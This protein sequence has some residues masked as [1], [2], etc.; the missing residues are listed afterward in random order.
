MMRGS[1]RPMDR[2]QRVEIKDF[3]RHLWFTK[4]LPIAI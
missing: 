4:P 2:G 1:P 3:R